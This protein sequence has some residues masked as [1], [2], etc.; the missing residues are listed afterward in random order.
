MAAHPP[1]DPNH[2]CG[3]RTQRSMMSG[4]SWKF[5]QVYSGKKM[6]WFGLVMMLPAAVSM[7]PAMDFDDDGI[8]LLM[9]AVMMAELA[10]MMVP[11]ILT[12]KALKKKFGGPPKKK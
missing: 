8:A 11:I 7:I 3:Y 5:A 10:I 4:E 6:E 9:A 1:K 2:F 12:E